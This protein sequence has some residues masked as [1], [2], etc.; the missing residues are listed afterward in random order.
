MKNKKQKQN[1]SLAY[2]KQLIS[3]IRGL[4]W[5]VTVGGL[6]LAFYCVSKDFT[7]SLPWIGAMIGLPWAAHATICAVYLEKSKAENTAAD[8]TGI[9][10]A[11]AA[12]KNFMEEYEKNKAKYVQQ[13][14]SI[15]EE[16]YE[17]DYEQEEI[18]L[19]DYYEDSPPI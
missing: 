18:F 8:G 1:R 7:G 16:N 12:A 15:D 9:V 4:L 3:D 5:V 17:E 6:L 14:T 2:S 13:T 19:D 10:Y 11:A